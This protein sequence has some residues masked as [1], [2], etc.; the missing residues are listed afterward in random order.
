MPMPILKQKVFAYITYGQCLLVFRHPAAPEAGIQAPA[1]TLQLD[2]QPKAGVLREA[3][4]ETSLPYL[5]D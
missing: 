3:L 5:R 4:E 1:G 2:A